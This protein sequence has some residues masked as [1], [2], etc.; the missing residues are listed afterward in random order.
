VQSRKPLGVAARPEIIPPNLIRTIP[1]E[2]NGRRL[3]V[4]A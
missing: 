2:E 3:L 1:A 4:T